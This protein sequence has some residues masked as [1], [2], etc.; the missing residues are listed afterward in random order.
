MGHSVTI[1]TPYA[2]TNRFYDN[3]VRIKLPSMGQYTDLR[4]VL[5]REVTIVT[6]T[7]LI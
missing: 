7:L 6:V 3:G 4:I 1:V 2:L 5:K